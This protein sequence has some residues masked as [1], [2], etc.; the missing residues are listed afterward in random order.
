MT[1][2]KINWKKVKRDADELQ[3]MQKAHVEIFGPWLKERGWAQ[4]YSEHAWYKEPLNDTYSCVPADVAVMLELGLKK[5]RGS[6]L[7]QPI[8]DHKTRSK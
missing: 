3:H 8:F 4:W 1:D 6:F 7:N 5:V 2:T